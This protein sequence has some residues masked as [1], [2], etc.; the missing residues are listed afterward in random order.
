MPG[1]SLAQAKTP[2]E[3]PL[4]RVYMHYNRTLKLTTP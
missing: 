3:K 2:Q 4:P 1:A